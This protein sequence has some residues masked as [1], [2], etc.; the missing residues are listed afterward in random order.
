MK[1]C[2]EHRILAIETR[3]DQQAGLMRVGNYLLNELVVAAAVARGDA[4]AEAMVLEVFGFTGHVAALVVE[5]SF[6]VAD[7]ELQVAHLGQIDGGKIDL[8]DDP[9]RG[10]IP[11]A[12]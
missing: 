3:V 1:L 5:E 4:H 10:G 11:D 8:V 2:E 7:K 9:R 12:A 6:A